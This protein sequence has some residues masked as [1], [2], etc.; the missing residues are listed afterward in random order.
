MLFSLSVVLFYAAIEP[1]LNKE[2]VSPAGFGRFGA[3]IQSEPCMGETMPMDFKNHGSM[4]DMG[5]C[6]ILLL[7]HGWVWMVWD[8]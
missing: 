4:G 3:S 7:I 8:F 1:I 2:S 6:K 5:G